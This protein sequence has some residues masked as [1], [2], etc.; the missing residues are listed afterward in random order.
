[1]DQTGYKIF[2][3]AMLFIGGLAAYTVVWQISDIGMGVMTIMNL[4]V[5]IPMGSQA[6]KALDEYMAL[7]KTEKNTK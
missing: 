6:L 4:I 7:R 5:L 1:M 2:S 3:L